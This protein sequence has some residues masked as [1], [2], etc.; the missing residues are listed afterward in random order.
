MV[1]V[2]TLSLVLMLA[3]VQNASLFCQMW[4]HPGTAEE[5]GCH[6]EAQTS[7]PSVAGP[8]GCDHVVPSTGAVVREDVRRSVSSPD[9]G[10][11]IPVPSYQV[12]HPTIVTRPGQEPGREWSLEKRPL[13][14]A[15]R[16]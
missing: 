9:A 5:S 15:L 4:C 7:L 14:S 10:Y 3:I 2:V 8:N 11:A 12:V 1:R 13:S 16:I 6:H